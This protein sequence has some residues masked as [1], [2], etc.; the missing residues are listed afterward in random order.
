M[1]AHQ[2]LSALFT[3]HDQGCLM[4]GLWDADSLLL[5]YV[6]TIALLF[7]TDLC[8]KI[9]NDSII[10]KIHYLLVDAFYN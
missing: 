7:N 3:E 9:N 10:H 8:S 5:K 2:T 1:E 6:N 4:F